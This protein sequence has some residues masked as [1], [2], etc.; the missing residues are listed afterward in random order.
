M[1]ATI[2]KT[3]VRGC[4][5][6][7]SAINGEAYPPPDMEFVKKNYTGKVFQVKFLFERA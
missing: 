1:Y 2:V 6:M 5:H 4:S 3:A 7:A